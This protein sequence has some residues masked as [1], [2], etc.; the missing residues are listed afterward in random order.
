[1]QTNLNYE[2]NTKLLPL[3]QFTQFK[4]YEITNRIE[5]LQ[6]KKSEVCI[7]YCNSIPDLNQQGIYDCY[8]KHEVPQSFYARDMCNFLYNKT[9]MY[10]DY[11]FCISFNSAPNITMKEACLISDYSKPTEETRLK[12]YRGELIKGIGVV[13]YDESYC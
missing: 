5:C 13:P 7:A 6:N 11:F 8:K 1:M 4:K 2:M 9:E 12:C 10:D 3:H